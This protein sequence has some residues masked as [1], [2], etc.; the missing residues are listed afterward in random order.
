MFQIHPGSQQSSLP[1]VSWR[2]LH[3][4]LSVYAVAHD[5][6]L[7]GG[8]E[9]FRLPH[10]GNISKGDRSYV[11]AVARRRSSGRFKVHLAVA[12]T[13]HGVFKGVMKCWKTPEEEKEV[14]GG[15]GRV[16]QTRCSLVAFELERV[17]QMRLEE[18]LGPIWDDKSRSFRSP[19]WLVYLP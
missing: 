17:R 5:R 16:C 3:H 2:P 1:Q 18:R 4:G 13:G 12:S 6:C 19:G 15:S 7:R 8:V 14:E 10:C 9:I 11:P